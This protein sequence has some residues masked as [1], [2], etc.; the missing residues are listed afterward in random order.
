MKN[1]FFISICIPSYNRPSGLKRLL[2]SIDSKKHFSDIQILICE[3]CAPNRLKIRSVVDE[4]TKNSPFQVKYVENL[5]NLGHGKNWRECS[6]QADGEYLIY[7]GD[8]DVFIPEA[9]DRYIDWVK[10]HNELGY[11]LRAYR[12]IDNKGR[13]EDFRYYG[14]DVFHEPGER[15]FTD[16]FLKSVFMSGYTIKREYAI[17]YVEESLDSTLYFQIYLMGEICLKYSSA[18]CNIPI[19]QMIGDGVSYFGTNDSEKH[20]FTPGVNYAGNLKCFENYFKITEYFDEK[21]K[22]NST[23]IIR[24]ELSKYSSY[25]TMNLYRGYGIKQYMASSKELR[26]I[27]LD[28][29]RYFN[30]YYIALLVFGSSFCNGLVRGIKKILGRRLQL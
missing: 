23:D 27:G 20:L 21:Y 18:Y 10:A 15:A 2:E 19:A 16:F 25:S 6:N 17:Q 12:S 24:M 5:V 28:C 13:V 14:Q 1:Q 8:D 7:M 26:K 11:I 22:F 30:L 9:L 3:D 29:S 4:Y